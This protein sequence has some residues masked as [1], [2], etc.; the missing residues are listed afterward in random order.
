MIERLRRIE[1]RV[2][3]PMFGELRRE[4]VRVVGDQLAVLVSERLG[5]DGQLL[6]A[7][8]ILEARRIV[9]REIDL[10]GI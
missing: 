5:D 2:V 6:A 10:G 8:E 3:D 1:E 7:L 9:V 4:R